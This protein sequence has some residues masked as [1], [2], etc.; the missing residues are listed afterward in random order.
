MGFFLSL[1]PTL[2]RQVTGSQA[3]L[4]GGALIA[5]MVLPGAL[6]SVIAQRRPAAHVLVFGA[7]GLTLGLALALIG[8]HAGVPAGLFVGA[9]MAGF[10]MGCS[11]NGTLRTLAPLAPPQ[12]RAGLMASF[13]VCSYLAFSVPAIG[14]GL[15]T[16]WFGLQGT[17][18]GYGCVLLVLAAAGLYAMRRARL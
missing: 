17:A 5:A 4:T 3:P 12:Q 13:F 16:G 2:A 7:V 11:F 6:A 14:A 10:S 1:G 9:L 18:L 15:A 8:I